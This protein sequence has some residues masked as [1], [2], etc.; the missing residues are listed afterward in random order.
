MSLTRSVYCGAA[1]VV[2]TFSSVSASVC[3]NDG[4]NTV[5][6]FLI[7]AKVTIHAIQSFNYTEHLDFVVW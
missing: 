4:L 5:W 3:D 1:N 6:A 2:V 7:L